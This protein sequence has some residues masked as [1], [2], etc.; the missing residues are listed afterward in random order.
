MKASDFIL[1]TRADLQEK[2]E[3]WSDE[4][5][6]IKLQRAYVALQFDLPFFITNKTIAIQEGI[7]AYYL[8]VIPLKNVSFRVEYTLYSF[9]DMENFYAKPALYTYS[10]N[11]NRLF[12]NP[13]PLKDYTAVLILK[14]QKELPNANCNIEI[15]TIYFKALRLLF[16]SEIHEKPTRNTKERVLSVHYIKLY[17]QE[18]RKLKTE[19][20]MRSRNLTSNY[21]RI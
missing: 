2:S 3:H 7:D 15:P 17:E 18:I 9:T 16:M 6:L 11:E 4:E 10:F 14:Y 19:Q 1:Q 21:Q 8:D 20:K 5:L 13:I 12:V